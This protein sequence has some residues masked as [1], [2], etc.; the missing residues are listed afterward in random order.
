MCFQG[1]GQ[2]F[3]QCSRCRMFH[4]P[5]GE[6]PHTFK[7]LLQQQSKPHSGD[8]VHPIVEERP[9]SPLSGKPR[10]SPRQRLIVSVISGESLVSLISGL[11]WS[12]CGH[13]EP[14]SR[15]VQAF[16][17]GIIERHLDPERTTCDRS[18]R[19]Y[20]CQQFLLSCIFLIPREAYDAG[21]DFPVRVDLPWKRLPSRIQ[22]R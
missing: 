20:R 12:L 16:Y 10:I 6:H 9:A 21:S 5:L 13:F 17:E 4:Q 22:Q 14:P 15:G 7:L 1:A 8:G 3:R 19:F 2:V 11:W 18:L